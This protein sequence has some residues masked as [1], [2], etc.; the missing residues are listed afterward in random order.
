M[1]K[2]NLIHNP[3]SSY[4]HLLK[5]P[6]AF[7]RED[8]SDDREFYSRKRI[9]QHLDSEA[10]KTVEKLIGELVIEDEPL[11]LDLMASIDSHIPESINP[12]GL[13]GLGL[14]D[15]ELEYNRALD[16]RIVQDLNRDPLLPFDDNMFDVVLNTVSVQYL[17][18]P[19]K[20]F[21]E[22]ARVL[23]PG[24]LHL[25]IFSN[26]TFKT[27]SIKIW[28]LMT[29]DERID[30][31]SAYFRQTGSFEPAHVF[32]SM[33]K[34]RPK[35]DKYADTGFP[36]DPIFAVYAEKDGGEQGKRKRPH[37][38]SDNIE[39]PDI[40]I[41]EHRT[42]ILKNRVCPYCGEKLHTWGIT[43]NPMTTWDHDLLVCVNDA[44]PYLVKGWTEMYRQGNRGFS[45]R[46]CIDPRTGNSVPVPVPNLSVIKSSLRD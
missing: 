29:D 1:S 12:S 34:P 26:R 28:E 39:L 15:E 17:T 23:K 13:V 18:E 27:K 40:D 10:L 45:Y 24:G 9:V 19:K 4:A 25:V 44:C 33:G 2:T 11:I 37:P 46:L 5:M 3:D 8:E 30:F 31:I 38:E 42:E 14:N 32:I 21:D 36:S 16:Q 43:D 7:S 41:S 6:D 35:D 22:V 20:I